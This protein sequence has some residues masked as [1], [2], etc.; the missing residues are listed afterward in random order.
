MSRPLVA[1]SGGFDPVH[2]GHLSL[3]QDAAVLGNLVLIL[4]SDDWLVRKKGFFAQGWEDRA[5]ILREMRS[6]TAVEPVDDADG[7][8]CEALR[9][10][11]PK[12]FANGGDRMPGEVPEDVVCC[13][14]GIQQLYLG[15]PEYRGKDKYSSSA[16]LQRRIVERAWGTYEVIAEDEEQKSKLLRVRAGG[17]I[18]GQ[19]HRLRREHWHVL[20]GHGSAK[21]WEPGSENSARCQ[22]RPG[23]SV[24]IPPMTAHTMTA[25]TDMTLVE[26]QTGGPFDEDDIVRVEA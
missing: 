13:E 18:S 17:T 16:V 9:R 2:R 5:A 22:L 8:V 10:I 24:D 14:L 1:V 20:S 19:Y 6:V 25:D 21:V 3:F 12:M 11:R 4:N 7:S 23:F 26:V 15:A